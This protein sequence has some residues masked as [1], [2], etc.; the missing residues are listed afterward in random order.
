[1]RS[2]GRLRSAFSING[3]AVGCAVTGPRCSRLFGGGEGLS[4]SVGS[5]RARACVPV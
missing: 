2:G 1:M 3:G 5:N 4:F